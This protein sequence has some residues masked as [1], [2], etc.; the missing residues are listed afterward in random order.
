M[1]L[2]TSQYAWR[3]EK[4]PY[5]EA[6]RIIPEDDF[7]RRNFPGYCTDR[8]IE[9]WCRP[10][11]RCSRSGSPP[12]PTP[13]AQILVKYLAAP[14]EVLGDILWTPLYPEFQPSDIFDAHFPPG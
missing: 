1:K 9:R 8:E 13:A 2:Y 7:L 12:R 3:L 6:L 14:N 5:R 11:A 4:A 10:M